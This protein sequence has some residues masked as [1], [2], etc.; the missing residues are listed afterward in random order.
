MLASDRDR[1]ET[2]ERLKRAYERGLLDIE[3]LQQRLQKAF[4]AKTTGELDRLTDDLRGR[5]PVILAS[6]LERADVAKR[7]QKG[8]A[9]GRLDDGQFDER[10][11]DLLTARTRVDL[12]DLTADLPLNDNRPEVRDASPVFIIGRQ[13]RPDRR[14]RLR[15]RVW[16]V[17]YRDRGW[18]DL[19]ATELTAGIT[20]EITLWAAKSL[21]DILIPRSVKVELHGS[22]AKKTWSPEEE[23]ESKLWPNAGVLRISTRTLNSTIEAHTRPKY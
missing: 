20:T 7:L 4:E 17:F 13:L 15:K 5:R 12:Q 2:V 19:R 11:R 22:G 16:L 18:L 8:L 9:D 21:I 3:E 10:M 23:W 1:E 14:V 6:D